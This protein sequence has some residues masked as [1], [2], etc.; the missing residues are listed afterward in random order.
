MNVSVPT[1]PHGGEYAVLLAVA[2]IVNFVFYTALTYILLRP[3]KG[4]AKEALRASPKD[5]ATCEAESGDALD[6]AKARCT[7]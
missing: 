6:T 5:V 7:K 3:W 1:N 2:G 4:L